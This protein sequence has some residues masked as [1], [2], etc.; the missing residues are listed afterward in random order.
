ML[1]AATSATTAHS[2]TG[3]HTVG[4]VSTATV[5]HNTRLGGTY[6]ALTMT[7]LGTAAGSARDSEIQ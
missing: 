3:V 4:S 6:E 5:S 1:E 2:E 7:F